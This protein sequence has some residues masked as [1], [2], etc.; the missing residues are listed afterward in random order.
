MAAELLDQFVVAVPGTLDFDPL[1][2]EVAVVD[3]LSE[4]MPLF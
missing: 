2:F 4:L 1:A 3:R